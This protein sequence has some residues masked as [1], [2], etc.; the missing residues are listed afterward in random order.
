MAKSLMEGMDAAPA[1]PK[2]ASGSGG[3]AGKLIFAVLLLVVAGVVV[4][5][6]QGWIFASKPD[7]QETPEQRASQEKAFKEQ[8]QRTQDAIKTGKAQVGGSS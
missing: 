6:S 4:A 7:I 5:W 3:Q 1:A 8:Q 2:K